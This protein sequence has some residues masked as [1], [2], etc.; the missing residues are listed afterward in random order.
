M[1]KFFDN[2]GVKLNLPSFQVH[3]FENEKS[4]FIFP[5][6]LYVERLRAF[7]S[8][9]RQRDAVA[10]LE[11]NVFYENNSR[12]QDAA[13][14]SYQMEVAS[15]VPEDSP[16]N[17]HLT[18]SGYGVVQVRTPSDDYAEPLSPWD[19]SMNNVDIPRPYLSEEDKK[20]MLE[21]LNA[22][23]LDERIAELFNVDVDTIRYWDYER[24]VEIGMCLMFIKRRVKEDYYA[25]KVSVVGDVR[26]IKT[27][28]IKYN[29]LGS[30]LVPI[31][32][33]MCD[34]FE[35]AVLSEEEKAFLI[36]EEEFTKMASS[37]RTQS[38]SRQP[39]SIRLRLSHRT[40]HVAAQQHQAQGISNRQRSSLES[41][42]PPEDTEE[43][44]NRRRSSRQE[45]L[46]VSMDHRTGRRSSPRSR[47]GRV[48]NNNSGPSMQ[49]RVLRPRAQLDS[50]GRAGARIQRQPRSRGANGGE[51]QLRSSPRN[52][53]EMNPAVPI[54]NSRSTRTRS[55]G[56]QAP[57][58][59]QE[60]IDDVLD[61]E[62]IAPRASRNTPRRSLG[63]RRQGSAMAPEDD[64]EAEEEEE[65]YHSDGPSEASEDDAS[66]PPRSRKRDM[67][68]P[69]RSSPR[70]R[71]RVETMPEESPT[72]RSSRRKS[73]NQTSYEEPNSDFEPED[74]E[75]SDESEEEEAPR[76]R[77]RRA[78]TYTEVPSDFDE[79][80][81]EDELEEH[82]PRKASKKRKGT[83][84]LC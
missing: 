58:E 12:T 18:G 20:L 63:S 59:D 6:G 33:K 30:D 10:G 21:N 11:V 79:E 68:P 74:E 49:G 75:P 34:D 15:F 42:P 17:P 83:E 19:F 27:N 26:L 76:G 47:P 80:S 5:E 66:P 69:S 67:S 8:A 56:L 2:L 40:N 4:E 62:E 7:E 55:G 70:A 22:L 60:D 23:S 46:R 64:S 29:G 52:G 38:A 25:A 82:V 1:N 44:P 71:R 14:Q 9:L 31:V 84:E 36:T 28:C 39:S 24:M 3:L 48:L 53:I 35:D 78:T 54:S 61:E 45:A 51:R 77:A 72:R 57:P 50:L 16:A 41:L 65:S 32:S 37:A 13:M 73:E 43:S 81:S